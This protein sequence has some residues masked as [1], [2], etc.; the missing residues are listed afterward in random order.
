MI[1]D[2][3][4]LIKKIRR[5][6][7][8]KKGNVIVGLGDDTAVLKTPKD[9][10]LLFT[11][12]CLVENIHFSMDYVKP[13][14]LG[15]KALAVNAS[16]IAAMGGTPKY[17]IV[18]LFL[19]NKIDEKWI[20][21]LY[22]GFEEFMKKYPLSIVGGNVSRSNSAIVID[23]AM[24]G[25]VEKNKSVRRS[26]AKVGD[27][28][29]VTGTLGSSKAG[30]E[31]L[32]KGGLNPFLTKK[33]LR[34]IPRLTEIREITSKMKLNSMI[35]ISDGFT[36]DLFHIL[37]ESKVSAELDITK[38]PIS[39]QLKKYAKEKAINY[40]LG[41]GEDYELLFTLPKKEAK[42][43]PAQVNGTPLTTVGEIV[44][45]KPKI[46]AGGKEIEPKGYNHFKNKCK[47]ECRE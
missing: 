32:K 38:I 26:G 25:E 29:V 1:K 13:A 43:L 2:E 10:D 24:L 20:N 40:A 44:K 42:K 9:K 8:R 21:E 41:G 18:S 30:M 39:G 22:K 37:E 47:V 33:H 15:W 46:I 28:I 27:L 34:P 4:S 11:C 6:I 23:I 5:T 31:I 7:G 14:D 36:Q 12:D 45:G 17:A 3:F 19:N 16:D 35:D